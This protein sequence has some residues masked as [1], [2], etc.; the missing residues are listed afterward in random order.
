MVF[1]TVFAR[2]PRKEPGKKKRN[3]SI[4]TG[5]KRTHALC[6]KRVRWDQ[7]TQSREMNGRH[8]EDWKVFV[9]NVIV[10]YT[11]ASGETCWI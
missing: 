1:L 5:G 6:V 8:S 9:L 4:V 2:Q 7:L 11:L 10:A 3:F